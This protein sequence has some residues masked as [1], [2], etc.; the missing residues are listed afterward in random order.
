MGNK[1]LT[2]GC[3]IKNY[4]VKYRQILNLSVHYL[5][6]F[7]FICKTFFLQEAKLCRQSYVNE[8]RQ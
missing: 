5:S 3:A 7:I 2:P 1:W 6:F 8:R 4:Q